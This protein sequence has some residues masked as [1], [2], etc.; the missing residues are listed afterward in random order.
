MIPDSTDGTVLHVLVLAAGLGTRLRPLTLEMPKPLVPL[1]DAP[2][3]AHQARLASGL[4]NV[5]LHVNAHWLAERIVQAAPSMGFGRVWIEEPGILGTGGPIHRMW[6]EGVRGELLVLN[7]DCYTNP[8]LAGF[9]KRSRASGASCALLARRFAKVDTLRITE[10]GLLSGIAN[11]FGPVDDAQHATFT[12]ISWY[13]ADAWSTIRSHERDVREF[14]KR[15]VGEGKAPHVETAGD[16]LPWIDMGDPEG[17]WNAIQCRLSELDTQAQGGN[18]VESGHPL[19]QRVPA[20]WQNSVVHVGA[21]VDATATLID[22]VLL[23]GAKV[24]AHETV[25]REIRAKDIEWKI[26]KQP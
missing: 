1:V 17:L 16:G 3:L 13:S 6:S 26:A 14:W 25:V 10:N 5:L 22:S 12:G 24:G 4:G 18:W 15:L 8:D 7:G 19:E 20:S 11:R 23:P 9:V 2:T 21:E